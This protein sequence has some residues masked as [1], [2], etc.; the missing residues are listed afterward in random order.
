MSTSP[1]FTMTAFNFS[2]LGEA[3]GIHDDRCLLEEIRA[4][5]RPAA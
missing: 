2:T 5:E 4:E 1:C 3:T